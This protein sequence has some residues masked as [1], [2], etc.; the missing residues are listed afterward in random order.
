MDP[1]KKKE[2]NDE[3]ERRYLLEINIPDFHCPIS[4][5]TDEDFWM[6]SIPTYG[7]NRHMMSIECIQKLII[8]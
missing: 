1:C 7:I 2:L 3:R 4:G 6:K 5:T 8:I